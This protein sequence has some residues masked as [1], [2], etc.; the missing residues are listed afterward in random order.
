VAVLIVQTAIRFVLTGG[1]T[2]TVFVGSLGQPLHSGRSSFPVR[3][4]NCRKIS[5]CRSVKCDERPS[6]PTSIDI[7]KGCRQDTAT[8]RISQQ[9]SSKKKNP[10]GRIWGISRVKTYFSCINPSMGSQP[11]TPAGRLISAEAPAVSAQRTHGPASRAMTLVTPCRAP[12]LA[13]L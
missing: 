12:Y 6:G 5:Q 13:A 4:A 10:A 1:A 2:N 11:S 3:P 8:S 9:E 7:R